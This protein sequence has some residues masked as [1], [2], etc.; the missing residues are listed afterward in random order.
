M[1]ILYVYFPKFQKFLQI[2]TYLNCM[3][4]SIPITQH[5]LK[6]FHVLLFSCELK[7]KLKQTEKSNEP[8]T[9]DLIYQ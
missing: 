3:H 8:P 4:K 2:Y 7:L 5:G 6:M 1:L 9:N